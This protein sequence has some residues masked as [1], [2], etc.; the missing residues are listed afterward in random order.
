M[1]RLRALQYYAGAA[2][3][4]LTPTPEQAA[5]RRMCRLADRVPRH[6]RGRVQAMHYE[7]DYVDLLSTCPQWE[8]LFVHRSLAF[9]AATETPRVL[10][11]GANIGLATLAIKRAHPRARVT[12]FEADP[13]LAAVL[14]S[15]LA[16]NGAH[17][18]ECV[19]A[20]V[21]IAPGEVP[22]LAEGSDSGA[23]A[24]V[25]ASMAAP[26]IQVR[27]VRLRDWIAREPI[28]LL[29]LDIEGA[30]GDVLRDCEDVLGHVAAIHMEVHDF[31]PGRRQLPACLELLERAGF[32]T[33]LSNLVPASWRAGDTAGSPFAGPP[34]IWIVIVKA[35][36]RPAAS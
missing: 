5:W 4:R 20:A 28:D 32:V 17:D 23:I 10:D 14:V 33:A 9:R 16:R 35:W 12:A 19:P 18:V 27:A 31:V 26:T 6:T 25:T 24:G 36:R 2:W 34:P 15:N 3:R 21:W 29:K 1:S 7:L 22:F 13:S 30:E 8:E 11:C